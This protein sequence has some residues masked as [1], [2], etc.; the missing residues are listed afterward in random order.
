M[1]RQAVRLG[2]LEEEE[3]I[4]MQE[5]NILELRSAKSEEKPEQ[6]SGEKQAKQYSAWITLRLVS[7]LLVFVRS[8]L[9]TL[10]PTAADPA[11]VAVWQQQVTCCR[12][13]GCKK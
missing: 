6:Q 8:G 2:K 3:G 1:R 7:A 11:V 12:A 4:G 13:K 9:P 5:D 10:V